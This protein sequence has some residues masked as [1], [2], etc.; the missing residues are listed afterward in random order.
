MS[1]LRIG[2]RGSPLALWQA[3]HVTG[4]LRAALPELAVELVEIQT[5][6]DQ[7]QSVPLVQLGGEG[8]S[9]RR[10]SKRCWTGASMWPYTA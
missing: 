3:H 10:S 2:T 9:P 8:L 6:G 7:V 1:P 5:L 4:L